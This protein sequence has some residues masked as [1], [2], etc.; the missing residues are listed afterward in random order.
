MTNKPTTQRTYY[1]SL[2]IRSILT[3]ALIIAV[4]RE[5]G[6]FTALSFF[7][8]FVALELGSYALTLIKDALKIIGEFMQ[9]HEAK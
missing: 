5:T 4:Y 9:D 7:I 2:A 1:F 8:V 3:I 6:F